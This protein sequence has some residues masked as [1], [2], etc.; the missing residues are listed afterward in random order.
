MLSEPKKIN[1]P[2]TL[3][4]PTDAEFHDV[5]FEEELLLEI[6]LADLVIAVSGCSARRAFRLVRR[7]DIE[8]P[9]DRLVRALAAPRSEIAAA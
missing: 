4:R 2:A 8:T 7:Q 1:M 6:R 5:D 3:L 9:A